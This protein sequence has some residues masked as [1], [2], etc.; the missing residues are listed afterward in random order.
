M[1]KVAPGDSTIDISRHHNR[2]ENLKAFSPE[3]PFSRP[4]KFRSP[5]STG[6][7][8]DDYSNFQSYIAEELIEPNLENQQKNDK[9]LIR[10]SRPFRMHWDLLMIAIGMYSCVTTP[11]Y[12]AFFDQKPD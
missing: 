5:D 3:T 11:F 9:R 7:P 4:G 2:N 12:V 6:N 10:I 1:M 8:E